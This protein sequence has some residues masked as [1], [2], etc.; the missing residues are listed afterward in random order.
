MVFV[1]FSLYE[2]SCSNLMVSSV[3]ER[4]TW[5]FDG[6]PDRSLVSIPAGE[7]QEDIPHPR[8]FLYN[9]DGGHTLIED[10]QDLRLAAGP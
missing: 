7:V 2:V 9:F 5:R 1:G 4:T 3:K 8:K 10:Y 6:C